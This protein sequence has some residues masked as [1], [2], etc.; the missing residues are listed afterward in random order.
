MEA[1]LRFERR[2]MGG[3]RPRRLRQRR[4]GRG[5]PLL[6]ARHD[7]PPDRQG[8]GIARRLIEEAIEVCRG[9]GEWLHV[10]ADEELMRGLYEPAGFKP[11]PAGLLDLTQ[12]DA[13]MPVI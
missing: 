1:S 7:G 8:R 13:L 4:L 12:C 6:P 5:R 9:H 2:G 10:D 11:T 3:G